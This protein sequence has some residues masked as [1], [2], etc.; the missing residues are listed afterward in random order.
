MPPTYV[1]M[2]RPIELDPN[3]SSELIAGEQVGSELA[4]GGATDATP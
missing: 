3:Y 4:A 1:G 2:L